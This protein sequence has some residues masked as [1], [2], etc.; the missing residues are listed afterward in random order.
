MILGGSKEASRG[1]VLVMLLEDA[2]QR[3]GLL[4]PPQLARRFVQVEE[5]GNQKRVISEIRRVLRLTVQ[6]GA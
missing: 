5:R 2:V 4:Q 1:R 6:S 3:L